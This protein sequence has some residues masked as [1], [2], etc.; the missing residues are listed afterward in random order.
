MNENKLIIQSNINIT[1][2]INIINN[3]KKKIYLY[4]LKRLESEIKNLE[5]QNL[6]LLNNNEECEV[7]NNCFNYYEN[8]LK[9]KII[10]KKYNYNKITINSLKK[11]YFGI[12][13]KIFDYL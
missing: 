12:K 11:K 2:I 8:L 13:I 6:I 9:K 7:C 4:Q 1:N 10:M 3:E 5:E